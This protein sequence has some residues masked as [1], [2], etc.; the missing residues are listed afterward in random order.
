MIKHNHS[1]HS[2]NIYCC[3]FIMLMLVELNLKSNLKRKKKKSKYKKSQIIYRIVFIKK[4]KFFVSME[5]LH[6]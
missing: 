2:Q 4:T 6:T 3:S 1:N 5:V